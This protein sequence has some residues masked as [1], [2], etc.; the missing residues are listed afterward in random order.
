MRPTRDT[1]PKVPVGTG[2]RKPSGRGR[3]MALTAAVMVIC[4]AAVT[5]AIYI[6]W[7]QR[8]RTV[9]F[10]NTTIN[11][12][13]ASGKT[14]EQVKEMIQSGMNGYV[15]TL[16]ARDG[17]NGQIAGTE[18]HLHSEYDGTLERLLSGQNPLKWGFHYREGT[19]ETI[20][21]MIAFD[22]ELLGER[23]AALDC[24]DAAKAQ[25][26][27]NAYLS[28]Y[29]PG[30]G[31]LIV[32]E[33]PG[34]SLIY[35]R[36]LESAGDAIRNLMPVLSLEAADAYKKPEITQE[37]PELI[38][39]AAAWNRYAGVTVVYQFGDAAERLD[40]D[41]IH[42]W[43]TENEYGNIVLDEEQVA[44]YVGTLADKYNTA[45]REKQLMTSY[46]LPVTIAKG[47]YGWRI[48]QTAETAALS[49][50]IRSGT[51]QT[52]EP[53]YSQM[54]ASHGSRDYG[55]TYVEINLT[56]QHL[57]FYKDGSLLVESDF[58]SGNESKGWSTP[59]GAYPLTYKQRNA[60]LKGEGY[61]T[62][63][64]YWM[65]FN[66]GIGM[67][68]AGWRSSFGGTIYKTGGSHGCIN[69]PPEK[70][71]TI[72]ENITSGIPVLC[73]HLE[74]TQ[75]GSTA[76]ERPEKTP[77]S[78]AERENHETQP[79]D[80][81]IPAETP[82]ISEN[83][84]TAESPAAPETSEPPAE[85]ETSL[86]VPEETAPSEGMEEYGP[87]GAPAKPDTGVVEGPGL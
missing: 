11:G 57:F 27:E 49:E 80:P 29:I 58:V 35:G 16:E 52:R 21:T 40:G 64:S 73:Y 15:L 17:R 36:V 39:K 10:P 55:D 84:G 20:S 14:V 1:E 46:G 68:D 2:A 23:L 65:P 48:N 83:P 31:Y 70:A 33:E 66:G 25:E 12:L 69:L 78:T 72:Y 5:A 18:I 19:A 61:A 34:N 47:N 56:A 60:T 51:G 85:D 37:N 75:K 79:E 13:D 26:P 32:P 74:G 59:S 62:P 4:M 44:A 24:M 81:Y 38:A 43:L 45:Y 6:Y 63:V 7:G 22:Q 54:A 41:I 28:A 86:A 77:E 67:H 30:T 42:T 8:Y 71:K 50:I 76:A 9:F 87:G 82:G 53:I 3:R